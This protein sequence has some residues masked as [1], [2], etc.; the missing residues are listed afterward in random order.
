VR[1]YTLLLRSVL[2]PACC[3]LLMTTVPLDTDVLGYMYY[4]T[5]AGSPYKWN[6]AKL[7]NGTLFWQADPKAPDILRQSLSKA[8]QAWAATL[9]GKLN[10]SE[11]PLGGGGITV[12]WDVTGNLIPDSI[13][14][15]YTTFNADLSGSISSVRII[16]NASNYTWVRSDDGYVGPPVGGK[17]EADLDSVILHEMGHALGLDHSDKDPTKIV[18]GYASGNL[19][20]MNSVILPGAQNLHTDD[21]TGLRFV[22]TG[23]T[24]PDVETSP[25]PP[26]SPLIVTATPASGRAPVRILFRQIGGDAKTAWDFGDG[27]AATGTKVAHRFTAPGTYVVAAQGGGKSGTMNIQ[28]ESKQKKQK[29]SAARIKL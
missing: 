12:T 15:A 7:P 6:L 22:Y 23:D 14:L 3:A 17:R 16:V 8:A 25:P 20:T 18:G 26:P 5:A 10:F 27:T 13:F 29:K 28:V 2:V 1:K 19:P 21:K 9:D 4:S 11:G 24:S